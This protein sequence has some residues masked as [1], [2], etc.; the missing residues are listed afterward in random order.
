MMG[1][2]RTRRRLDEASWRAV[3]QR[4]AASGSTVSDFCA[5]EGLSASAFYR[6]RARLTAD[7][8]PSVVARSVRRSPVPLAA[9]SSAGFIEL[10]ELGGPPR[11]EGT[12]LEL[13]LDLGGG[14][15][16]QIVRR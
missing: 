9:S 7:Q 11:A 16:L 8:A 5:R 14:V 13:R 4:F 6:W 1:S 3:M 15:V 2:G 10:G 12:A